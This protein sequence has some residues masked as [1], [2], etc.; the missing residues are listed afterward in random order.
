MLKL[1]LLFMSF[2]ICQIPN[3]R[4][5]ITIQ[6]M[7]QVGVINTATNQ[8]YTIIETEMQDTDDGNIDCME[9]DEMMCDMNESC[10]WMMGMCMETMSNNDINTPHFIVMDE[11]LGYWFVTTIASGYVAQYS[12]VDNQFID[13][14]FVGD[15]PAILAIDTENKK[16]YCSRMMSMNG[17]GN[18]MPSSESHI[19]HSLNYS[20][21]GLI[22][23]DINEY[24]I[25]SPSPHGLAINYNGTE[26]YTASNTTDWLYKVYTQTGESVGVSMGSGNPSDQTI[27][28]LKPIQCLS[29]ENRLFVTCSAGS[30]YNPFTG[31]N[32]VIPGQLQLW[33]S[34][35]MIL[36]NTL[37]LGDYTGPWHIKESSITN[38]IYVVLSGDSLYDTE[39][40]AAVN[41]DNDTLE[42]EW[43]SS[44]SSFDT[45]HGIDVSSDGQRIYVSGR[46]DG[47]I[48]VFNNNGEYLNNIYTG[49]MAMLGGICI[50]KEGVP[51]SGD[52]NNDNIINVIDVVH[53]INFI[54][55][56]AIPSPYEMYASDSD[57]NNII[58]VVDIISIINIILGYR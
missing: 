50:I 56:G 1:V 40:L 11:K 19:I 8:I 2:I 9:L 15:A 49:N 29:I 7:D 52:S 30:W 54:I 55:N 46:G 48:H 38:T 36:L 4:L 5:Y 18:M 51:E 3:E 39:G 31:E 23:S 16:I 35:S 24:Q 43:I 58:N 41:F 57:S 14:Y 44:D 22:D 42:L 27:Q 28:R 20:S 53:V 13:S 26:I 12:L 21:M 32:T 37:E 25:G 34:D 6:M 10:E 47:Y 33:D 17:M 45:L